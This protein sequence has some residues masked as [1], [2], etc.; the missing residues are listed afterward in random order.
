MDYRTDTWAATGRVKNTASKGQKNKESGTGTQT[1]PKLQTKRPTQLKPKC[2]R[3]VSA[4]KSD[5]VIL[6]QPFYLLIYVFFKAPSQEVSR[7][8]AAIPIVKVY[9][10]AALASS[11]RY[12]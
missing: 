9:M 11:A 6:K 2:L 4:A 10:R 5:F 7:L 3:Q 8:F 1:Q 12:A